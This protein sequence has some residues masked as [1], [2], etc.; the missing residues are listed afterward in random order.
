MSEITDER[1]PTAEEVTL[2]TIRQWAERALRIPAE[3]RRGRAAGYEHAAQDVLA[4][5]NMNGRP[6]SEPVVFTAP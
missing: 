3:D 5:L 2:A 6:A 4:I 1:T